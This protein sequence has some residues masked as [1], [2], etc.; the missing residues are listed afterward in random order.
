M[1]TGDFVFEDKVPEISPSLIDMGKGGFQNV[2]RNVSRISK[3]E[4]GAFPARM[5][6]QVPW[7]VPL[8]ELSDADTVR[9]NLVS[10]EAMQ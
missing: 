7:Q 3:V 6:W 4:D 5:P 2:R 8:F 1:T 9:Q 10:R